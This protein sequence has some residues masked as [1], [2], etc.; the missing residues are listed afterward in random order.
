M[1][2][3]ILSAVAGLVALFAA[4]E[5]SALRLD[6]LKT[7]YYNLTGVVTG[8]NPA[9]CAPTAP[10][11]NFFTNGT[12]NWPGFQKPGFVFQV[13][14]PAP[15]GVGPYTGSQD[16]SYVGFPNTPAAKLIIPSASPGGEAQAV[17][18]WTTNGLTHWTFLNDNPKNPNNGP[19]ATANNDTITINLME[20]VNNVAQGTI[21][22]TENGCTVTLQVTMIGSG[23]FL[24]QVT[25]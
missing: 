6:P 7:G 8:N 10:V 2:I 14:S 22:I 24:T 5:A 23:A 11:G 20:V 17:V 3:K 19:V 4:S 1:K 21:A 15:F 16:D 18:N 13:A 25:K 12:V 9:N